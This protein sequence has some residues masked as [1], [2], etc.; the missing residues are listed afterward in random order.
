M[1]HKRN[2]A[3]SV[4]NEDGDL[5]VIGG[6]DGSDSAFSTEIFDF[7]T[8]KWREGT[9]LPLD[10]QESGISSHCTV[11]I[12]GTHVFMAGGYAGDY[13]Q[14][15]RLG[16]FSPRYVPGRPLAEA[17][18]FVKNHWE[19]LPNMSNIRDRPACA[20]VPTKEGSPKIIVAGGCDGWCPESQALDTVE[21]FDL[22]RGFS[23]FSSGYE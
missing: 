1:L 18:M 13:N 16:R 14:T 3:T 9:P 8:R 2:R 23:Q 21:I 5:W 12:N 20:L 10:L 15:D 7:K 11:S 19:T 6:I 17:W 4:L 22:V